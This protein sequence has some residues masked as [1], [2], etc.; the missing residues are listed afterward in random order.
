MF[1][2]LLIDDDELVRFALG[3][4]LEMAEFRVTQAEHGADPVIEQ[5]LNSE[6]KPDL[7]ISDIIMPEMEGIGLLMQ[8]KQQY[9]DIPVINISGGGRVSGTNY[10]KTAEKLGAVAT[11]SKPL[12]EEE[13]IAGIHRILG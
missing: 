2:I 5:V 7:I 13:L 8:L 6:H 9:P 1:H 12:D 10:L 11:F 4:A 3:L